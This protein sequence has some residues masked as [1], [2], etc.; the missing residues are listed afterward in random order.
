M[1][2]DLIHIYKMVHGFYNIDHKDFFTLSQV[3]S[4]RGERYKIFIERCS[5]HVRKNSLIFRTVNFWN[6][7]TFKTKNSDSINCFK[8]V[9]DKELKHLMFDY[10]E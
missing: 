5:T 9:I 1:R 6:N 10:D 4:T 3:Q 7:L 8:N 2:G